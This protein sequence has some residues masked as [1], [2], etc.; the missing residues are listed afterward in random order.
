MRSRRSAQDSTVRQP[1]TWSRETSG[2][3]AR[4]LYLAVRSSLI[5]LKTTRLG[6]EGEMP[7]EAVPWPDLKKLPSL[8]AGAGRF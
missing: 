5:V 7:I 4:R 1:L 2:A 6:D 8:I 3:F